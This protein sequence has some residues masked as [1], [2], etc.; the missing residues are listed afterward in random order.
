MVAF[1]YSGASLLFMKYK[2]FELDQFQIDAI[3]A[4]DNNH[5]VVVSAATGTGKTLTADYVIDKAIAEGKEVVYTSPIKAL[6]NQKYKEFKEQYGDKVGLLTGDVVINSSAPILIMT[7]EIYRN[8]LLEK[9]EP[10]P[11]LSYVVFDEIHYI[12]D[13]ERGTIWEESI[14]FSPSHVR[15][16]CLS[17]TI[18]NYDQFANWI[19]TIKEHPVDTVNYMKRAVPLKHELFDGQ[20]GFCDVKTLEKKIA[21][22]P[23]DYYKVRGQQKSKN[24]KSKSRAPAPDYVALLKQ[25]KADGDIPCIYFTFSRKDA[26]M[27]GV[28]MG[29]KFDYTS[30]AEK[31]TIIEYLRGAIPENIRS[32]ESVQQMKQMLQK[33]FGVHHAGILPKMKEIVEHLFG[34]GLIKVLFATETFAVGINMPAKA[35][36]LN[37]IKKYDGISVRFLSTKEYFQMAGRAGRRGI[38]THGRVVVVV[39]RRDFDIDEVTRV[40]SKDVEPIISQYAVSYN[41]TLNL[42]KSNSKKERDVILRSNFGYFA[43]KGGTMQSRIDQSFVNYVRILKKMGYVQDAGD[44][45]ITLTWKGSFA[46]HIFAYELMLTELYYAGTLKDLTDKEFLLLL[47]SFEYEGRMSDDFDTKG[48][49][50]GP[51]YDKIVNPYAKKHLK[52]REIKKLAKIVSYWVDGCEFT[53]LLKFCNLA[54]G[55][56]IR[57]FRRVIDTLRQLRMAVKMVENDEEMVHRIEQL[58]NLYDR[59]IIRVDF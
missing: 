45:D 11:N 37:A 8:M 27:K 59:D 20:H 56:I 30:P 39:D 44:G 46:T 54:E 35:V 42:I 5:S 3:A 58:M 41:T 4:I 19:S 52:K 28:E 14:I 6:S 38:D 10:F 57:L 29:R 17:A 21:S 25:L 7:T 51:L 34:E 43:K 47:T 13:I 50:V 32:M 15:F 23:P 33:G 18:P 40:T 9:K 2:N 36:V 53:D 26:F 48:C 22:E 1:I 31:K 55:D 16:L 49:N 24:N 12:N